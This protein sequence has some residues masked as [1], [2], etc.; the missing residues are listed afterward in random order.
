MR[1]A[2]IILLGCVGLSA[3]WLGDACYVVQKFCCRH[4]GIEPWQL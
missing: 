1:K 4:M 2:R 3:Q